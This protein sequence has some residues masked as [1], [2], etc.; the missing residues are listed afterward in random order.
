MSELGSRLQ[1]A[2]CKVAPRHPP[3]HPT[4]PRGGLPHPSSCLSAGLL[5]STRNPGDIQPSCH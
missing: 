2:D 5:G 1:L 3:V 4:S